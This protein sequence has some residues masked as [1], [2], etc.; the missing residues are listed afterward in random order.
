MVESIIKDK[1]R[2]LPCAAYGED[3]FG[4]A[5]GQKGG[6]YFVGVPCVL[7]SNGM[8]RVVDIK[9]NPAEKKLFDESVSH[10]KDL[11][12]IVRKTFPELA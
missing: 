8:E 3:D 5:P 4:V 2:I 10:V 12:E 11:V 9:F 1:K 6:G 7:G